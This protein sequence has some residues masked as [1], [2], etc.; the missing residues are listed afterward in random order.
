MKLL[1]RSEA[2]TKRL[3]AVE[4]LRRIGNDDD[5]EKFEA[6]DADEYAEHK[7]A[8]ILEN[9]ARRYRTMARIKSKTQLEGE[10][11][12]ANDYIE[13]LEA[14]LDSIV[15]IAAGDEDTEEDGESEGEEAD[16]D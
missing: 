10:L 3:Q 11:E 15:G 13:E 4:F 6:M 2:E 12:S 8:K 14:K 9:P 16:E 5:A 1:T 7:G